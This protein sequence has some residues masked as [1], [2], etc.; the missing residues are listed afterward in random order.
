VACNGATSCTTLLINKP[1]LTWTATPDTYATGYE[2]LRSTTSG[3][4]YALV[5]TVSGRTTTTFT[6]TTVAPLTTYF[7]VVRAAFASWT[8]VNSNEVQAMVLA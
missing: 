2:V 4:G 1:V 3:S 6:D 7:Y 8:S 5:G